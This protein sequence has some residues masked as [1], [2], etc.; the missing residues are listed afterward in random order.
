MA[1]YEKNNLSIKS[2]SEEDRPREKLLKIGKHNLSDA[3]LLAILL[4]S[5]SVNESAVSLAKRI[6]QSVE[7]NL[8]EL[9]KASIPDLK[10]FK[11]IGE[12]KA[13]TIV[14][15][16]EIGRRRQLSDIKERPKIQSSHDAYNVIAPL[17][18]DLGHE[19]FW[20][21][22]LNRNNRV[23]GRE[24]ISMGGT[25]GTVVDAKVIFRKAL[26]GKASSIILLHNHPSGNLQPSKADIDITKKLKN[27][28]TTIDI[29]VLDHLIIS[30]KGYYSFADEGVF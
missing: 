2:W 30:E 14:A 5:G 19:E 26:E 18:M 11:G 15:A 4:G 27:A 3:E 23:T 16:L 17:L 29:S 22:L 28:G 9:G 13:I 8:H 12:A 1:T 25:A 10:K 6:L 21:L 20:I 24:R 7:N